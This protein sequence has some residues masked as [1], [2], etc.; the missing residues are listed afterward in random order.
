MEM[1]PWWL[2]FV[3]CNDWAPSNILRANSTSPLNR[4]LRPFATHLHSLTEKWISRAKLNFRCELNYGLPERLKKEVSEFSNHNFSEK[5]DDFAGDLDYLNDIRDAQITRDQWTPRRKF[6][7]LKC[8]YF[9]P[10]RFIHVHLWTTLAHA[11]LRVSDVTDN[12]NSWLADVTFDWRHAMMTA[13]ERNKQTRRLI[14][15]LRRLICI[16]ICRKKLFHQ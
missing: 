12:W 1:F 9:E 2:M 5:M 15:F 13:V 4:D 14:T 16:Y 10:T 6:E 7:R 3:W 8:T 11:T